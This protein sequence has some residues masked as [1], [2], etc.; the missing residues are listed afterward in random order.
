MTKPGRAALSVFLLA[1][2]LLVFSA[3]IASAAEQLK[4]TKSLVVT[5]PPSGVSKRKI[6]W[7][8]RESD[9]TNT[10]VGDPTINGAQVHIRLTPGGDQCFSMPSSAW[11]AVRGGFKYKDRKLVNGPVKRAQIRKSA[12]GTFGI[13]VSLSAKG[14]FPITIVPGDP[15]A[16]YGVNFEIGGAGD[17]YCSGTGTAT[18]SRNDTKTFKLRN[19]TTPAICPI[20]A[21]SA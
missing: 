4:P 21:C 18:P 19:D 15:T 9:S 17:E 11:K 16:S 2:S 3:G 7:K 10:I 5:N 1:L 14:T 13:K 8:V 6:A 20:L 12:T